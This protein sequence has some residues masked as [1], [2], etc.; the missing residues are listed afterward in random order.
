MRVKRGF[1]RRRRRNRLMKLTKGFFGS[2]KNLYATAKQ[3]VERALA[4][5]YSGR[6]LKKRDYRGLWIVRIGAAARMNGLNYS[7]MMN[8]LKKAGVELDRKVLADLAATD[9]RA[10]SRLADTAREGLAA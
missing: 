7:R 5:A 9:P 10:F 4:S 3:A 2:R 6:R 1:K 8:G